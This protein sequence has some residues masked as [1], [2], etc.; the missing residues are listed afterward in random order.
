MIKPEV[1]KIQAGKHKLEITTVKDPDK[2]KA[3]P[4][5]VIRLENGVALSLGATE[6]YKN[7][8][9]SDVDEGKYDEY[10]SKFCK[11]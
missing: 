7:I 5:Y 9:I 6:K 2:S 1:E 3:E 10:I 11:P 8:I 4:R